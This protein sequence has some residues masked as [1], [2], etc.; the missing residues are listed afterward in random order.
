MVLSDRSKTLLSVDFSCLAPYTRFPFVLLLS[1]TVTE[2]VLEAHLQAAAIEVVK[3]EK[4]SG[5]QV[6]D[7][8]DLE[9]MF[10]SGK[11]VKAKFVVGADGAKSSV[12][13]GDVPLSFQTEMVLRSVKWLVSGF[14]T[15]TVIRQ[16][17]AYSKWFLQ[18]LRFHPT[19]QLYQQMRS[20]GR[21]PLQ[22]FSSP[23]LFRDPT[24]PQNLFTESGSTFR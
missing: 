8:G 12:S 5:V 11:V 18:M 22:A 9:V 17:S 4:A 6:G 23:F 21:F 3:A 13:Y 7:D 24:K 10:D 2:E 14:P 1:Q 19:A 15:Q 16:T 20:W